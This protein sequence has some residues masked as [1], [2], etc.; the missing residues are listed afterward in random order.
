MIILLINKLNFHLVT[1]FKGLFMWDKKPYSEYSIGM[2]NIGFGKWRV[3][4]VDYVKSNFNGVKIDGFLF[5]L[6]F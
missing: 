3:L 1:G 5:G 2:D 4:R 6:T